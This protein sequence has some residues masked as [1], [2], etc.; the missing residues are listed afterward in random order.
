[1]KKRFNLICAGI[2]IA[3][4]ISVSFLFNIFIYGFQAGI[5]AYE[6]GKAGI[7]RQDVS[8]EVLFTIPTAVI[9][10]QTAKAV[11]QK[12]GTELSIMPLASLIGVPTKDISATQSVLRTL[13]DLINMISIIYALIQFV[14][15]VRNIHRNIIFDWLNVKRLRRLGCALIISYC[16]SL[17]LIMVNNHFISQVISLKDSVFSASM[18]LSE[19]T[20]IIG[21]T[22]LLFGEIFA[23]GLRM[24]EENDM[25]I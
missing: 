15:M 17:A 21:F 9:N 6:Q 20:L 2:V 8:Y 13:L 18:Q 23:I 3:I 7:E 10:N 4:I 24:K 19:P 14:K 16:S 22:A 5:D 11:N 1:M 25:T 12:D